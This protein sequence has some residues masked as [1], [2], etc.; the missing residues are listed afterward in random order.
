M[1]RLTQS[2]GV[3]PIERYR[4]PGLA[5]CMYAYV[6][7]FV[8]T[9]VAHAGQNP[10][11]VAVAETHSDTSQ[12]SLSG[13]AARGTAEIAPASTSARK[14]KT[15][16]PWWLGAL[17][18][19]SLTIAFWSVLRMPLGV[20]NSWDKV[21]FWRRERERERL[22]AGVV[23]AGPDRVQDALLAET[24]AQFGPGALDQAVT[25]PAA[26]GAKRIANQ[27]AP[28]ASHLIFLVMIGA[29]GVISALLNG[30]I[31]MSFDLGPEHRAYFGDGVLLWLVLFLGGAA[32]GFGVRLGG[33]CNTGHG[34]SGM[35]CLQVGSMVTTASFFGT[36]IL[37]SLLLEWVLG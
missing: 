21:C 2:G 34:L 3:N 11:H 17:A 26:S 7:M 12:E 15:F 20:S 37:V 1:I 19:G 16:W 31:S 5:L 14:H 32:T 22:K 27:T 29:G 36:A 8:G 4:A 30:G 18:L 35:G 25:A 33:G 9:S 13:N 28:V 24:L 10:M 6:A 23:N